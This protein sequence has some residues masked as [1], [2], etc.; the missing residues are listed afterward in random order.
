[1]DGK[2][3]LNVVFETTSKCNLNC[4]YCYNVHKM[5][6]GPKGI[7]GG[8]SQAKKTLSR[9]FGKA[10]V[11]SVTM[12]GGEPFLSERFLELAL[13]CRMKS[14]QVVVITNG[15]VG[16]REDYRALIDIG[17]KTFELPLHSPTPEN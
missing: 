3:K 8:F 4:Q 10:D 2:P 15:T 1:M 16:T 11:S 6:G 7:V 5:P 17:V 14:K 12:S 13:Y 9:L